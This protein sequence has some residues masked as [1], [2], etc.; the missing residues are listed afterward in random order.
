MGFGF[1]FEALG[2]CCWYQTCDS[3]AKRCEGRERALVEGHCS[4]E[5]EAEVLAPHEEENG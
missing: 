1:G 3:K 5:D 2:S 4:A